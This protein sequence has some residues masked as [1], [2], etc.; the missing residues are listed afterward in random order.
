[1]T[2]L[3][4]SPL[5]LT[6]PLRHPRQMLAEQEYDGHTSIHDDETAQKLGF[7]GAAIEG[8]THFS[9]FVPLGF[10]LWGQ[11]WFET[12]CISAH[13]RNVVFDGEET[14]ALMETGSNPHLTSIRTEKADGTEVLKG[15]ASI[16]TDAPPSALDERLKTLRPIET[17]VILEH[18]HVGLKGAETEEVSMGF[19]QNMGALYPFSLD[20]KLKVITETCPWYTE[21][22]GASSPWGRAVVPLEMISVLTQ[23][24]SGKAAFPV[25]GPVVGLFAD[26]EIRMIK[27]P[28]FVGQTYR[29]EREV[30]AL[31]ES[32]RTESFWVRTNVLD[33]A[34]DQLVAQMLLNSAQLKDSYASYEDEVAKLKT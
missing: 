18:L 16:G 19:D 29:L 28:L 32:R 34:T 15:T 25:K 22:G 21:G 7:Q 23:Y 27:G 33:P 2:Q 13:Y 3:F 24:T 12:G 5:T 26:Q 31:S 8:P 11:A 30:V 1:M 14:R 20:G 4:D 6:G 9:Q 10:K 17:P